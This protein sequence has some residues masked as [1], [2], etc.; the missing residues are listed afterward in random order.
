MGLAVLTSS[1]CK[2]DEVDQ[3]LN[4]ATEPSQDV[5]QQIDN[6]LTNGIHLMLTF[7]LSNHYA[8]SHAHHEGSVAGVL[9]WRADVWVAREGGETDSTWEKDGKK[10]K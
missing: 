2:P 7:A 1:G 6:K 4:R 10:R 5:V 9:G 3:R 8:S